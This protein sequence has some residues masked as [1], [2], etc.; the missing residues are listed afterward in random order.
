MYRFL[1]E[2]KIGDL[3]AYPSQHDKKIHVGRI[4]GPYR[5]APEINP[6]YPNMRQVD[7]LA[8]APRTDFSQGALYEI[9]SAMSFF[10]LRN[11]ADE[12]VALAKG[13]STEI[14][15]DIDATV[16]LVASEVEQS[17]RDY[18]QKT[19]FQ[20]FKGHRFAHLVADLLEV[21][22]YRTRVSPPGMD[23][24]TDILA[25]RDELGLHPPTIRVQVKSGEGTVGSAEVQALAGA[26]GDKG[27]GLF[28]ALSA[29]SKHAIDFAE[30]KGNVRL[31]NGESLMDLLLEHYA[32]LDPKYRAEIPLKRVYIPESRD[33]V[34]D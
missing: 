21:M 26:V 1:H 18:L 6:D 7:W 10:M 28:V 14:T 32:E 5:Y 22:G 30:A 24:G 33:S 17:T 27:I 4:E 15:I 2:A 23:K 11:Y 31:L 13:E 20:K 29:F 34:E 9:G 16:G 25:F 3:V 8:K 19:L 12:F